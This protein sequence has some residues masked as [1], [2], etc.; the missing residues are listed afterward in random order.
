LIKPGPEAV[1][2]AVGDR[3]DAAQP[4]HHAGAVWIERVRGDLRRLG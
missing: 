4:R 3:M 1:L 2:L